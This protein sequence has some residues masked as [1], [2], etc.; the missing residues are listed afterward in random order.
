MGQILVRK[1]D[2]AVLERLKVL[3]KDQN[4]PVEALA[5]SALEEKARRQTNE[6]IREGLKRLEELWRRS[7]SNSADSVPTLRALRDGDD[8][9]A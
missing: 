2:D 5:R 8:V 1:I 7:P 4:M 9:D 6:E 3:A